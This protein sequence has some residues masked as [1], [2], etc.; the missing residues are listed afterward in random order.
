MKLNYNISKMCVTGEVFIHRR[1]ISK[2]DNVQ[3]FHRYIPNND[4]AKSAFPMPRYIFDNSNKK[5][6]L[7]DMIMFYYK[8]YYNEDL[9]KK[10]LDLFLTCEP[11]V[12]N[13][14]AWFYI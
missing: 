11:S 4:T 14:T 5:N 1:D 2:Q 8:K 3:I 9:P 10:C 7:R 12:K 13:D 6:N